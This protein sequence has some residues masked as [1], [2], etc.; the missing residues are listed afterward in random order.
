MAASGLETTP[1]LAAMI[2]PTA[3]TCL[4]ARSNATCTSISETLPSCRHAVA[5]ETPALLATTSICTA[6][7]PRAA[8][9]ASA[10]LIKRS[11]TVPS[12]LEVVS[13]AITALRLRDGT[14]DLQFNE[15]VVI[16]AELAQHLVGGLGE[17]GGPL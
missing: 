7:I 9:S 8:I 6:L 5:R 17:L 12:S 1:V 14:G 13:A 15:S 10:A 3:A 16:E 11:F 4:R 2:D